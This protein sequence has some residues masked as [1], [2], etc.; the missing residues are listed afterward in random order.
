MSDEFFGSAGVWMPLVYA[1]WV[2]YRVRV[3]GDRFRV[4]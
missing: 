1:A 4:W 3:E 2:F